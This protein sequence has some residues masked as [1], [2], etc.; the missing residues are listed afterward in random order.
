MPLCDTESSSLFPSLRLFI[1]LS[2]HLRAQRQCESE[3]QRDFCSLGLALG[4]YSTATKR[5]LPL[6]RRGQAV[7]F[8]SL[9]SLLASETYQTVSRWL[10][11]LR[12]EVPLFFFFNVYFWWYMSITVAPFSSWPLMKLKKNKKTIHINPKNHIWQTKTIRGQRYS[13]SLFSEGLK[14]NLAKHSRLYWT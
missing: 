11:P 1:L 5:C 7:F 2:R 6:Q 10:C 3:Y 14:C 12:G 9:R 13:F 4:E 8:F